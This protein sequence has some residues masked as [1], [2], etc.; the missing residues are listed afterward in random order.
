MN[1]PWGHVS[2][3]KKFDPVGAAVLTVIGSK[4]TDK[5]AIII[6]IMLR[7]ND[8][9][10]FKGLNNICFLY[11]PVISIQGNPKNRKDAKISI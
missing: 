4:Q 6:Y 7:E 2:C 5:R 11:I 10:S 8:T 3:H 1:L 9:T